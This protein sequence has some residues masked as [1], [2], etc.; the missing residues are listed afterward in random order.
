MPRLIFVTT[1]T[2][3]IENYLS[4]SDPH[5]RDYYNFNIDG[6]APDDNP[7]NINEFITPIQTSLM[8]NFNFVI[9][10][11]ADQS[12]NCL[13]AEIV[14]LYI[15]IQNSIIDT[16]N[17]TVA[18]LYSQTLES[19][20]AAELNQSV[21]IN[22]LNFQT[23]KV[24]LYQLDG[25]IGKNA[26]SFT[27]TVNNNYISGRLNQIIGIDNQYDNI[28][29]CF[30]G[31]YKGLIP[32]I[33]DYAQNITHSDMYCIYEKSDSLIKYPYDSNEN[34]ANIGLEHL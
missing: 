34:I 14:T 21:L 12:T 27:N 29:F 13:S 31:G 20:I 4:V 32:I 24:V 8:Q 23:D 16:N 33:S 26:E 28:L 9:N 19:K 7:D 10:N 6:R 3:I 1:G 5:V 25:I 17:D 18:M 2:S 11:F 30:S 22:K 15:M